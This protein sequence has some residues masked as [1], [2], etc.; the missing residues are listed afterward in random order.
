MALPDFAFIDGFDHYSEKGDLTLDI[1]TLLL[2]DWTSQIG[3]NHF[4]TTALTGPA[5]GCALRIS[6]S[7]NGNTA[8]IRKTLP[9]NFARNI[10]GISAKPVTWGA[11]G[12][13]FQILFYDG[14]TVQFSLNLNAVSGTISARRGDGAATVIATSVESAISGV[15]FE[16]E[17]DITFHNSTGI[18]KVWL[19]GT[20]TSLNLTGQDTC[21]TAN[22]YHNGIALAHLGNTNGTKIHDVDH[23]YTYCYTASG[24]SETPLLYAPI[25]ETQFG[26]SDDTAQFNFGLG[27]LGKD[28]RTTTTT[29]APGA[30]Q[31]V[32]APVT[33]D[34]SGNLDG[35]RIM[36]AATSAAAKFKAVLYADSAGVPGALTATGTEVVGCTSG[37]VLA[38]PFAVGQA[39]VAGTQY[40]IGYITD[41][42]VVIQQFDSTTNLGRKLAN[43]YGSGAPN[44]AGA[45][46]TGQPTWEIW[47][48][49]SGVTTMFSQVN[50]KEASL[51]EYNTETTVGD[52]DLFN[53]PALS[54][55]PSAIAMVA[56]RVCAL[57]SDGGAR[58]IDLPA[59]SAATSSNG[60]LA[61]QS[62]SLS[63]SYLSS[64]F[65]VDP[66]TGVAWAAAGV[67]GAKGGYDIAA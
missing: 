66:N 56:H 51:N 18:I 57:K 59:K 5:A 39:V 29:S 38:L 2:R 61:A 43:T 25:I 23:F 12:E 15:T 21:A 30:N 14:T 45:M 11:A 40:W 7:G 4:L 52:K 62:P 64:N 35:V 47:G 10:G 3:G 48:S 28:Y 46:T 65:F 44:P 19:N 36:P 55:T 13:S 32:L 1:S 9:G 17:W 24:G 8:G 20:L 54:I 41:T 58:T 37:T 53:F 50:K 42:S 26:T 34:S 27:V 49:L 63:L 33:A 6:G 60:S 16:L 67:N 22:N 31:L